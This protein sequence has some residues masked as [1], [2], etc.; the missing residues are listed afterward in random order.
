[1]GKFSG[2]RI[3]PYYQEYIYILQ[4]LQSIEALFYQGRS[5]TYVPEVEYHCMH[6][7]HRL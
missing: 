6:S 5:P 4:E 2:T 3:H 1:M 7:F